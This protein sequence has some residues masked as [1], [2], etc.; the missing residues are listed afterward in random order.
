MTA[1]L[2]R[3]RCRMKIS[4]SPRVCI[5]D[6]RGALVLV[7]QVVRRPAERGCCRLRLGG[8]AGSACRIHRLLLENGWWIQCSASGRTLPSQALVPA[9]DSSATNPRTRRRLGRRRRN[10]ARQRTPRRHYVPQRRVRPRGEV[11]GDDLAHELGPALLHEDG[12]PTGLTSY[13]KWAQGDSHRRLTGQR[14]LPIL[15]RSPC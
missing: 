8:H 7:P 2:R 4:S 14:S 15:A 3:S 13:S 6:N 12:R 1:S 10:P 5:G 11:R 9:S